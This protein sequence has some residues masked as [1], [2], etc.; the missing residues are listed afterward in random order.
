M[1]VDPETA[2]EGTRE[3]EI[4]GS[5][6]IPDGKKRYRTKQMPEE[7]SRTCGKKVDNGAG[8]QSS[9]TTKKEVPQVE[10]VWF[11]AIG[12]H[13]E[14]RNEEEKKQTPEGER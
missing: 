8:V 13:S 11:L 7:K 6:V 12:L 1:T 4:L 9:P 10:S 5:L 3:F 14:R 2:D